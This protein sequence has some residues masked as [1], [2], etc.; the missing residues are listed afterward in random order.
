MNMK[1]LKVC[2][3]FGGQSSE[4]DVSRQSA[5]YI[6][7]VLKRLNIQEL[8]TVGITKQGEF[9]HYNGESEL[10]RNNEWLQHADNQEVLFKPGRS[11][12][13][14]QK[15]GE[16]NWQAVDIFFPVLHGKNGEDGTIQGLFDMM[17]APFVGCGV[18]ASSV[19]MD[20]VASRMLFDQ[21]GIP[22]AK[23]TWL[24]NR[25]FKVREEQCISDIE[26][27]L[28]Y[29]IFVKPANAGSSVGISKAHNREE[30][31]N[32]LVL[33]FEHDEKAV[34]EESILGR[35]I[36]LAV[37]EDPT[38]DEK[39][40]VSLPGEIIPDREFYDF[41]SKYVSNGSKL[42]I[43]ANLTET[44]IKELQALAQ[45]TFETVDGKGLSRV[46]FFVDLNSGKI[47]LN[48]INTLPGFT[49]ISMYPKLMIASG[50][51]E[52]ELVE[53]LLQSSLV[54]IKM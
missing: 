54:N 34:L 7:D 35:E 25:D 23:W 49:A 26:K 2:V 42:L 50:Y 6:I 51:T 32:A 13:F 28:P 36:E 24:R 45:K 27:T 3:L 48:E 9:I 14:T 1:D 10:I 41:E 22:Q 47:L 29:P 12:F 21:V 53:K 18:L 37:L 15:D 17:N 52:E 11:G 40:I 44:E 8:H 38:I 4:H 5:S 39:I 46:D 33:A 16:I 30:L 43:P 20:K 19:S 31:V